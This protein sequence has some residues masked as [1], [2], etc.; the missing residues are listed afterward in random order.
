[1]IFFIQARISVASL[2]IYVCSSRLTIERF[3]LFENTVSS[4]MQ[5]R[6]KRNL[7]WSNWFHGATSEFNTICLNHRKLDNSFRSYA[8]ASYLV[9]ELIAFF[10][11]RPNEGTYAASTHDTDQICNF[12]THTVTTI[13]RRK[14]SAFCSEAGPHVVF[15]S[16]Q[17]VD[18]P[19][20]SQICE[21]RFQVWIF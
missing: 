15:K 19:H 13:F 4:L 20:V 3:P 16:N 21:H 6:N 7:R 14:L 17:I 9:P 11:V 2:S 18:H 1:M 10:L 12:F 8:S 5:C